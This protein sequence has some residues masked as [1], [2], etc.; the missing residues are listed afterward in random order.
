VFEHLKQCGTLVTVTISLPKLFIQYS[1]TKFVFSK[2][3]RVKNVTLLV[4]RNKRI[5]PLVPFIFKFSVS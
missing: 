1:V 4:E 3:T 2:I 5:P